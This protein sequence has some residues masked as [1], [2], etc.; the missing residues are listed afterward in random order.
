MAQRE[1]IRPALLALLVSGGFVLMRL[2]GGGWDPVAVA[3]IGSQFEQGDEDGTEGYDGQ[4]NYY[5]ALEPDPD[6]V[7]SRLDVPAYRYQRILYPILARVLGFADPAIIPWTLIGINLIAHT[8]GT[9][10][11]AIYLTRRGLS[12]WYALS[13]GL[14]VGLV[15]PVG[16]DLSEALAYGLVVAAWLLLD[17]DRNWG[18]AAC[19]TLA[20]FAKETTAVFWAAS[21][22][23]AA[24]DRQS[25]GNI[26]PLVCGGLA[27]LVW[28]VW[29]LA[30]FGSL[31][32]ASGGAMA[33]AFELFPFMGLLRIGS[34]SLPALG[35]YLVIFGPSVVLPTIWAMVASLKAVIGKMRTRSSWSMLLHSMM[36]MALPFSTFREPLGLVRVVDGLLLAILFFSADQKL[37]R[38][39][40]YALIWIA[41][42]VVLR[43]D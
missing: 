34:V 9:A 31:G 32:V 17:R 28:Q 6:T 22:L 4:F 21:L 27:F 19:L 12:G 2:A 7:A 16:L 37:L 42:L 3:E 14:W 35:L 38:P 1:V 18:G 24:L 36:V 8:V 39:L 20:L 5:I 25:R 15:G 10:L 43:P 41:F 11:M 29:L 33:T 23:V 30:Q 26:L 40:R 13:Y